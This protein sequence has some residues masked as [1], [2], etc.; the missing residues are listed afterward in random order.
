MKTLRGILS[1]ACVAIL[2]LAGRQAAAEGKASAADAKAMLERAAAAIK[3]DKAKALA[4]F[5]HG[6]DGFRDRDLYV[7]APAATARST[8]ISIPHR[9]AATSRTCTTSTASRSA[10]R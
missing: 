8:R 1:A 9:S 3:A 6:G 2:L 5:N 10:R 7:F 4:A